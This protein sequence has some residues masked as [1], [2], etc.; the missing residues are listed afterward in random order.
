MTSPSSVRCT[1]H[2]AA[3]MRRRSTCSSV[4]RVRE[5]HDE[6]E[7]GRAAALGGRVLAGDLDVADVPALARRVHLH[8]DGRARGEAR[9]EQLL[10]ARA[11]VVAAR[12]RGLVDAQIVTANPHDVPEAAASGGGL[13]PVHLLLTRYSSGLNS[14]PVGTLGKKYVDFGGM[15]T[16]AAAISRTCSTGVA[17]RKNAASYSPDEHELQRLL[18]GAAVA[19]ALEVGDVV[20]GQ[21]E[22]PV[23]DER[24]E[25]RGVEVA[26]G[27][28]HAVQRRVGDAPGPSASG[29][30][31]A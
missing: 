3:M 13:H 10:R 9:G 20:L 1:G 6:P 14:S 4:R 18:V 26:V 5:A 30:S 28:G 23:E 25:H 12:L 21:A 15:F 8:R 24:L 27:L 2:F 31:R 7:A 29:G 16:P 17:R 11:G 19:E 22:R